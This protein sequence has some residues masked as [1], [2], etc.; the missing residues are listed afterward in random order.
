MNTIKL[1]IAGWVGK[2]KRMSFPYKYTVTSDII[3][4]LSLPMF[5]MS[6]Y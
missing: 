3:R 4:H 2:I 6:A 5:S 1:R